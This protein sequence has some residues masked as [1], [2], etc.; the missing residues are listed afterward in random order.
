[1]TK[2]KVKSGPSAKRGYDPR[3]LFLLIATLMASCLACSLASRVDET[4]TAQAEA[5]AASTE[6]A[7]GTL[8]AGSTAQAQR[9]AEQNATAV[10]LQTEVAQAQGTLGARS[11]TEQAGATAVAEEAISATEN[12][13]STQQAILGDIPASAAGWSVVRADDFASSSVDWWEGTD[14]D[15]W[16]KETRSVV[17]G[18][19]RWSLYA[20]QPVFYRVW[21]SGEAFSDFYSAVD[22]CKQTGSGTTSAGVIFRSDTAGNAYVFMMRN[23]GRYAF[24]EL[25]KNTWNT[26]LDWTRAPAL[27]PGACN[28]IEVLAQGDQFTFYANGQQIDQVTDASLDEGNIGLGV[29]LLGGE[30]ALWEFDN[31]VIL[32]P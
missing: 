30:T 18:L 26:R 15:E 1:V 22:V 23:N 12:A 24:Y 20:K 7:M 16:L 14:E 11:A 19:Y 25:V 5:D 9:Q 13:R 10:A 28:R 2:G 17:D 32:A 8:S 27:T 4:A 21:P 6:D 31:Y 29:E 3:R